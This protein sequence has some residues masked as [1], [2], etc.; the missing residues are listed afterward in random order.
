MVRALLT[1][2][3][4]N[5]TIT[6][7]DDVGG[8]WSTASVAPD[9]ASL[10]DFVAGERLPVLAV[11]VVP[12][13]LAAARSAFAA[14]GLRLEVAGA[15]RACPLRLAYGTPE[16][17]GA[18]RWVG[19]LAAHRRYGAA[20]TVD[21]GTATTVNL[22]TAAGVFEGGAIGPGPGAI[23]A[24]MRATAPALPPADLDASPALPGSTTQECVD[25]GVLIG[26]CGAVERLVAETRRRLPTAPLV[27]TGGNA[28]RL[29]ARSSLPLE[30][31]PALLHEGLRA[32][33]GVAR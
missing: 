4:G 6:C 16:T 3:C 10:A 24:G 14:L 20:V 25:A 5:S 15:E 2:D 23:V 19:A 22:V 11:S 30:H 33:A 32:L 26:W 13:A 8:A 29:L 9:F 1:V 27:V 28:E 7:C 21:C 18:D 12:A 31:R 17:L